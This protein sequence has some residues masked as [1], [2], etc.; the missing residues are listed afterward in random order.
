M[1]LGAWAEER[2]AIPGVAALADTSELFRAVDIDKAAD[3][4]ALSAALYQRLDS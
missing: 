1:D 3:D 4:P 2:Y